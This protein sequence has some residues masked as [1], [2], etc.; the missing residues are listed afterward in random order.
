MSSTHLPGNHRRTTVRTKNAPS[1]IRRGVFIRANERTRTADL[2]ITSELLYQLSYI[3]LWRAQGVLQNEKITPL[4]TLNQP[5]C[6]STGRFSGG[7][8]LNH[9]FFTAPNR[10]VCPPWPAVQAHADAIGL[11]S[12]TQAETLH[13]SLSSPVLTTMTGQWAERRT[14]SETLPTIALSKPERP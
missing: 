2:L 13:C 7:S 9:R 4:P 11:L 10:P 6:R 12:P 8:A 1:G 5:A 14:F 3:G